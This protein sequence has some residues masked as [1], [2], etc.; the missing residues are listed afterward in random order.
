M[1]DKNDI[2]RGCSDEAARV[3]RAS[4]QATGYVN[5]G[6][7]M[8][9][10]RA[11]GNAV[12]APIS[13]LTLVFGRKPSQKYPPFG[14]KQ[15]TQEPTSLMQWVMMKLGKTEKEARGLSF[16]IA[17]TIRNLG[18]RVHRG[19]VPPISTQ[20]AIDAATAMMRRNVEQQVKDAIR[21]GLGK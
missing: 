6:R 8:Q 13:I 15:G 9:E 7:S 1:T 12:K 19:I 2:L 20:P 3:F 10:I 18:N 16:V 17:R 5:T 21:D 11:E 4:Y 14:Y